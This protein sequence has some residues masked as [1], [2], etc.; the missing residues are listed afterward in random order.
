[1]GEATVETRV[2][3]IPAAA[4]VVEV[5]GAE[6][7]EAGTVAVATAVATANV[8]VVKVELHGLSTFASCCHRRSLL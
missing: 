5:M 3:G 8:G 6:E 7:T 2:L 4:K 1:M